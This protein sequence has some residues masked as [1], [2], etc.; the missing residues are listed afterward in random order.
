[1]GL[2]LLAALA[3]LTLSA[4]LAAE[5]ADKPAA[6]P[7]PSAFNYT[8][9]D[10]DERGL[11]MRMEEE[12]RTLKTSPFLLHDADLHAY[13]RGVLCRTVG[14]AACGSVRIYLVRSPQ[15]NA[16]MAPNGM[17]HVYT[18]LLLRMRS[19]AELAAV[20]AHEFAHFERQHSLM[21]FRDIR[22]KTDAMT[23]LS[24]VPY[25]GLLG[26]IAVAGSVFTFSQDMEKDADLA[27]IGYLADSG[28]E[29]AAAAGI[30]TQL[31]AEMD[32]TAAARN[33]KS[34]KNRN[35]GFFATHPSSAAR[36][37]Y[38]EAEAKG[39]RP[40]GAR[41]G[42][43]EYRAAL[44]RW[45]PQFID[46]QIKLNDFGGTDFLL[47]QLGSGGWTGDLLYAR[48]ELL[49]ARGDP[50]DFAAAADL[51]RK[52]IEAGSAAGAGPLPENWR[53]L[54]LAM[55]RTGA[56]ADGRAALRKYMEAR[57]DAADKAMIAMLA[58]E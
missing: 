49:R 25:V 47:M 10:R 45:W 8:P 2:P 23:W 4:P 54:G 48:A 5:P 18:G 3:A 27:S 56:E 6:R 28:Y 19:E 39:K 12:E 24:F 16:A 35:G 53:G 36:L 17:M 37:A 9:Q 1:M 14:E 20:L 43:P 41:A 30:W 22:A 34:R 31:R 7:K 38:L 51:Y 57:P 52:A 42:A 32:A 46:D 15:F 11:W 58:G 55:L 40:A 21:Q 44:S 33:Q 13:V 29:P 26:Q 50:A